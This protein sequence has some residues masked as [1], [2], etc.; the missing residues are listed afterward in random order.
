M[1]KKLPKALVRCSKSLVIALLGSTLVFIS[2]TG[3]PAHATPVQV[4][5]LA[6]PT[7]T[8]ETVVTGGISLTWTA[9]PSYSGSSAV[10]GYQVEYSTDGT[11]YA[12]ASSS[13]PSGTLSYTITNLATGSYYV[14][15]AALCSGGYGAYGYYWTK[16][17]STSTLKRDSNG[18]TVYD[19]GYGLAATGG[20][21]ANTLA[22]ASFSRVRYQFTMSSGTQFVYTDFNKFPSN[23]TATYLGVSSEAT[24]ANLSV[25]D[26]VHQFEIQTNVSDMSVYSSDPTLNTTGATGHLEIWPFNYVQSTDSQYSF[27]NS[28]YF[29]SNDSVQL[30]GYYGSFQVFNVS[31]P[32]TPVT[33]FVWNRQYNDGTQPDLGINTPNPQYVSNPDYT[34]NGSSAQQQAGFNLS[35]Y[36]NVPQAIVAI[37]TTTTLSIA[38]STSSYGQSDTL[39][40]TVI[41][42]GVTATSASGT[43]NFLDNG[44]SITGCNAVNVTAGIATCSFS[45]LSA[46]THSNITA[47]YGG[48]SGYI[49]SNSISV[50]VNIS[51]SNLAVIPTAIPVLFGG[52]PVY[53]NTYSGFVNGET[54]SSAVFTTGLVAPTCTSTYTTSTSVSASPLTISCSGGS[55]TNHTFTYSATANL[56]I[57][58]AT[59]TVS[60]VLSAASPTYGS[61]DT[62][63]ATSSVAGNVSFSVGGTT[64]SGCNL[65]ATTLVSPFIANCPWTP[66]SVASYSLTA[67]ITPTDSVDYTT[68]TSSALNPTSTRA[69]ITVTPTPNQSKLYGAADPVLTYSITSGA[70]ANGDQLSGALNYT[71]S[72]Q[73]TAVGSYAITLGT[74]ANSNYVITLNP[75][76][77]TISQAGQ[78]AVSLSALAA[79]YNASNKTVTLT[80]SGGSGSGAYSY[81]LDA[82]NTTPG[83]SVSG[84]TLSYTTAGTCIID[85]T[86][87]ASTNYTVQINAVSFSIGLATQTISFGAIAT[88]TYSATP[89]LVSASSTSGLSVVFTSGSP[90]VC[91]SSG[92][93]GSSITF[94]NV[95]TC[96]IDANQSGD[97]SNAPAAQVVQSFTVQS[98][99]ITITADAKTKAYGAADPT[100]TYSITTGSLITGDSLTGTLTRVTGSEAGNYAITAGTMTSAN[101]PKYAITFIQANLTI[102]QIAPSL[103]LAYPNNNVAILAPGATDTA[104]VTTASS[105]GALSFATT[106]ASSIC[107]IDSTSGI[108]SEFGAGACLVA[109]TSASTTDYLAATDTLTVTIVLQS[110]S[111]SG[112]NPNNLAYLG[113]VQPGTL[114]TTSLSFTSGSNGVSVS[115]PANSLPTTDPI[116]V[117]LLIDPS[118]PLSTISG[119]TSSVLS[120]V[121]SWVSPD[122]SIP[123]TSAGN[124]ISVTLTNPSIRSGANV[125]SVVGSS[126]NLIGTAA[127][128]GSITTTITSDP[129]LVVIN[130]AVINPPITN[131]TSYQPVQI[132]RITGNSPETGP[133]AGGNVETISGVFT[134]SGSCHITNIQVAGLTLS[135]NAWSVTPT[136]ISITMPTH[137]AGSVAIQIYDG[138]VPIIP[139]ISYLY[140]DATPV[141]IPATPIDPVTQSPVVHVVVTQP[142][143]TMKRFATYYFA[144]GSA[145]LTRTQISSVQAFAKSISTSTVKTILF[146]GYADPTPGINNFTLSKERATSV[147]LIVAALVKNKNLQVGWYGANKPL[148]AGSSSAA[149]AQNRRVEI[150]VK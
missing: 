149:N 131:S 124:P 100:F 58:R 92:T 90:T 97:S 67:T 144:S 69:L 38:S 70:L 105:N 5:T 104:T 119:A 66:S 19:N 136:A 9:P 98:A 40:A 123:Q 114:G 138:C 46:T 86:K 49:G 127:Q 2:S 111:L 112:I 122:G 51:K 147:E 36:I 48:G 117:N 79:T 68:A 65:V 108:I 83:C 52:T 113:V 145:K 132:D 26:Q 95:G 37:P 53:T 62:I 140:M 82:G 15:V 29:D 31:T 94:L 118:V 63:T 106:S 88:Q 141:S 99:P 10:T 146:Y 44:S 148:S 85:V 115:V 20:Q 45:A 18:N 74:L 110:S 135:V 139:P 87:A 32:A 24:V 56:T 102:T 137:T 23:N 41:S 4:T 12:I 75:A 101:N 34:F 3:T 126:S 61:V 43:M 80:G 133:T 143:P 120:V 89:L 17:Y 64:I 13:I 84:S 50:S 142:L 11:A 125:Y 73:N 6:A 134:Q 14:R 47:S 129:V 71:N 81:A 1:G 107:S 57:S 150:W 27:G 76:N 109:M 77:F 21:A 39:T 96:I 7:I 33:D 72:G 128:D 121:L 60:I 93:L 91:I 30:S 54:A 22:S 130:P 103:A 28:N 25:P 16:L 55:S 59:P 78:S 35:I 42:N 8:A 116:A